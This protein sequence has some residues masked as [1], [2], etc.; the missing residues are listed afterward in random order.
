LNLALE[1]GVTRREASEAVAHP[2]FYSGWGE[3]SISR[4]GSRRIS[5]RN[6]RS[7]ELHMDIKRVGSQPV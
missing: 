2:T 1:S 3:R 4:V 7:E 6:G 5:S